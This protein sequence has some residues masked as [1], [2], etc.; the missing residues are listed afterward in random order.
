MNKYKYEILIYWS[1][2]DKLFICEVPELAG[3]TAD[4]KTY[5]EA[6]TNVEIIIDEWVQTAKSINRAIP[7][8]KG[9]LVFS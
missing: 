9:K 1:E 7:A 2:I 6:L 4:G 5:L 3:C 8:P